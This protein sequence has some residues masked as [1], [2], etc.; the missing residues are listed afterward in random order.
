MAIRG[1]MGVLPAL[2]LL[3]MVG[4]CQKK[5][6]NEK[7]P[8]NQFEVHDQLR[9]DYTPM[10]VPNAFGEPQPALRARLAPKQ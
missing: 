3:S 2:F 9:Q 5:L 8:R 10:E 4:G 6:F 7:V 1:F